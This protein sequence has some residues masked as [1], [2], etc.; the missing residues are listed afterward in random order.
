MQQK[1][2]L[3]FFLCFSWWFGQKS[4]TLWRKNALVVELVD[5][6]D[7]GSGAE[8]RVSSSL[9]RR[10][11]RKAPSM[12]QLFIGQQTEGANCLFINLFH[13]AFNKRL[14]LGPVLLDA[15]QEVQ[16]VVGA[17]EVVV[18]VLAL[19]L[20]AVRPLPLGLPQRR[21]V[22]EVP[23]P[24]PQLRPR[25]QPAAPAAQHRTPLPRDERIHQFETEITNEGC[26]LQPSFFYPLWSY[27]TRYLPDARGCRKLPW[28]TIRGNRRRAALCYSP[29]EPS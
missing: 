26:E 5:T 29:V 9:I 22:L 11:K 13:A 19:P 21:Q 15:Q 6:P 28:G 10:T 7:L 3:T 16:L 12:S 4:V 25:Q 8:R 14:H 2:T 27:I 17:D 23:V 20:H 18:R 1:G 24:R